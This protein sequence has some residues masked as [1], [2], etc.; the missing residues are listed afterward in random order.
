MT[1]YLLFVRAKTAC[2]KPEEISA[3]ADRYW[4]SCQDTLLC[5]ISGA[6]PDLSKPPAWV[7]ACELLE[8][9][10]DIGACKDIFDDDGVESSSDYAILSSQYNMIGIEKI[11]TFGRKMLLAFF[12]E[13][14]NVEKACS[15]IERMFAARQV[16][17]G[18]DFRGFCFV[19]G[20]SCDKIVS[21]TEQVLERANVCDFLIVEPLRVTKEAAAGLSQ[22]RQ[23]IETDYKSFHGMNVHWKR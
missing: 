5:E 13:H 6:A 4:V 21:D 23:W 16:W 20:R 15:R 18:Q 10:F 2:F 22:L 3:V 17:H 19:D 1:N 9:G 8:I 7:D 11:P 14:A 12:V